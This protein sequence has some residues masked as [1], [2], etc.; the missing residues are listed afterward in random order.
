VATSTGWLKKVSCCTVSTANFFLSHPVCV[1]NRTGSG[2]IFHVFRSRVLD[3]DPMAL[4]Y[5]L[6]L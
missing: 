5:E 2:M 4:I 1:C 3:L 6:D